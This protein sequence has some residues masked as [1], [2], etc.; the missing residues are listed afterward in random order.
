MGSLIYYL[1]IAL[2]FTHEMDAVM[3][4]EWQL[5]LVLR[6]MSDEVAYPVFLVLHVPAFFM[7]FW[8]SHHSNRRIQTVFRGSAAAFLV[9]HAVIHTYNADAAA[10][11]FS[12]LLSYSLIYLAAVAGA[13]YLYIEYRN[14][15]Q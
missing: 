3:Y 2:L 4:A 9:L 13:C 15:G 5:L 8:L 12:G 10:N 7:F 6:D 14:A 11:Q 1:G